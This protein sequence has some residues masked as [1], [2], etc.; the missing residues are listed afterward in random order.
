M[1]DHSRA[2]EAVR[3]CV[4]L[5]TEGKWVRGKTVYEIAAKYSVHEDTAKH[6]SAEASRVVRS[7]IEGDREEIRARMVATLDSIILAQASAE[8]RAAVSAIELQAK[9][10]GLLTQQVHVSGSLEQ[11]ARG[12]DADRLRVAKSVVAAL[13]SA[14]KAR[15]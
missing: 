15:N 7:A 4:L 6:W 2:C 13:E 11:M 3:E 12:E 14:Q 5:M 8:P 10:L 9:L 1:S